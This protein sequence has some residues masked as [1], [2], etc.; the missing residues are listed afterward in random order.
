M[1]TWGNDVSSPALKFK[2]FPCSNEKISV[3]WGFHGLAGKVRDDLA[4]VGGS[5]GR[6][7]LMLTGCQT[8][9]LAVLPLHL[10]TRRR[11]EIKVDKP[12]IYDKYDLLKEKKQKKKLCPKTEYEK[13]FIHQF[14][15]AS[16][17]VDTS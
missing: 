15:L 12:M 8:P 3:L 13:E 6:L 10:L 9:L 2:K 16:R 5:C 11:G 4:T 14:L 7:T 17:C 1:S